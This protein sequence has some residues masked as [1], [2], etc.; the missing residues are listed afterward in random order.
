MATGP[1]R[2]AAAPCSDP[3]LVGRVGLVAWSWRKALGVPQD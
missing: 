3:L 2:C 1:A